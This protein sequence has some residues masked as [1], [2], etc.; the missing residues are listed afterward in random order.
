MFL[1]LKNIQPYKLE[2]QWRLAF[3][4]FK[5]YINTFPFILLHLKIFISINKYIKFKILV[6]EKVVELIFQLPL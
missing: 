1:I 4:H 3:M 2:F 6:V 5:V